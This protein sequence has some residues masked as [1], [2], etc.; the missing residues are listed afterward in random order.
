MFFDQ[1]SDP[2]AGA[3][4]APT[5][6]GTSCM[7][8]YLGRLLRALHRYSPLLPLV[9]TGILHDLMWK[10]LSLVQDH[11]TLLCLLSLRHKGWQLPW[12]MILDDGNALLGQPFR[13]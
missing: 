2:R 12:R 9:S 3:E 13:F 4:F 10:V 1:G 8:I 5:L 7:W 11:F 6:H